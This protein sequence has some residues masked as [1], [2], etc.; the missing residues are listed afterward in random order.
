MGFIKC[1]P[2]GQREERPVARADLLELGLPALDI[3]E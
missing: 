3:T 2:G 1:I